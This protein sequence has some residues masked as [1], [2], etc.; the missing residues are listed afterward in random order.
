MKINRL[1]T[2]LVLSVMGAVNF[3]LDHETINFNFKMLSLI[4]LIGIVTSLPSL[5]SYL[6]SLKLKCIIKNINIYQ[7]ASDL[8]LLISLVLWIFFLFIRERP[9][10]YHGA[11]HLYVATWPIVIGFFAIFLFIICL[12]INYIFNFWSKHNKS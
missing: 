9:E 2:I 5:V 6:I 11:S 8:I 7:V 4:I 10:F 1:L 3:Y 12:S